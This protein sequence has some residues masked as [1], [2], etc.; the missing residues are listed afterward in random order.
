MFKSFGGPRTSPG[1]CVICH[2]QPPAFPLPTL[3]QS[4]SVILEGPE[5]TPDLREKEKDFAP[6]RA[7]FSAESKQYC[8]NVY[9]AYARYVSQLCR[10]PPTL[11]P[12]IRGQGRHEPQGPGRDRQHLR[13]STPVLR[14]PRMD[15]QHRSGRPQDPSMISRCHYSSLQPNVRTAHSAL[16]FVAPACSCN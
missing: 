3:S 7:S 8:M 15:T 4:S 16:M 5:L 2:P 1:F 6:R 10:S 9:V 14:A 13:L 12:G 11:T